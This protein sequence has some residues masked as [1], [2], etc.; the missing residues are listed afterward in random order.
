MGQ[1]HVENHVQA[2]TLYEAM[3]E[4]WKAEERRLKRE[5]RNRL[6]EGTLGSQEWKGEK[7]KKDRPGRSLPPLGHLDRD[8]K[9]EYLG[10]CP[11]CN[12]DRFWDNRPMK[13]SGQASP[14]SADFRC[15]RCKASLRRG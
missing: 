3:E 4:A 7:Y 12:Y 1:D 10:L 5:Q 13:R 11:R 6:R 14:A 2:A 15:V 8:G 9:G